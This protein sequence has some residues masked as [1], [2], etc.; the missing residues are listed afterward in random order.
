MHKLIA[1]LLVALPIATQAQVYKCTEGGKTVFSDRPCAADDVP[2]QV[3][4]ATGAFDPAAARAAEE[5]AARD[6]ADLQRIELQ[7]QTARQREAEAAAA[8]RQGEQDSCAKIREDMEKA[9]YWAGE[10]RHPDNVRRE[11]DKAKGLE[12]RLWWD[13]RQTR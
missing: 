1:A 3:R 7:R 11:R 2:V 13:C 6:L 5:R 9:Y 8:R 12:D 10:F 4:P